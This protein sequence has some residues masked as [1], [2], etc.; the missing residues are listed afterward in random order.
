RAPQNDGCLGLPNLVMVRCEPEGRA[1]NHAPLSEPSRKASAGDDVQRLVE[2]AQHA[3][4]F[5]AALEDMA[6]HRHDAIGALAAREPRILLDAVDRHFGG[7]AEHR[8]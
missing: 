7:A 4:E 5:W 1:S 8:K 3:V 6:G 2:H